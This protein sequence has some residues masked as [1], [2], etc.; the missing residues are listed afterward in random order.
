MRYLI[1]LCLATATLAL[2]PSAAYADS[3]PGQVTT[4]GRNAIWFV[5]ANAPFSPG[6]DHPDS[7]C[8]RET[9][10]EVMPNNPDGAGP[11]LNIWNWVAL[12]NPTPYPLFIKG[13]DTRTTKTFEDCINGGN[14]YYL[15]G[16]DAEPLY[17][18]SLRQGAI[19]RKCQEQSKDVVAMCNY[20][21][22]EGGPPIQTDGAFV[23]TA[24]YIRAGSGAH[25]TTEGSYFPS[26]RCLQREGI[27]KITSTVDWF[28]DSWDG[29]RV[30]LHSDSDGD[31]PSNCYDWGWLYQSMLDWT[32][33]PESIQLT[34]DKAGCIP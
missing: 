29:Y 2:W 27:H 28:Y 5:S 4:C 13:I 14:V 9:P 23:A 32:I 17:F 22:P 24:F 20:H 18:L 6:N 10:G 8:L 26:L 19:V 30:W 15:H 33:A 25:G 34:F 16:R 21:N 7:F 11:W 31:G 1:I 12:L 3:N